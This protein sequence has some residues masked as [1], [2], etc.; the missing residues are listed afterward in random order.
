MRRLGLSTRILLVLLFQM[1]QATVEGASGGEQPRL[2][3]HLLGHQL[4]M[5]Q[6]CAHAPHLVDQ[7]LPLA[8]NFTHP[9]SVEV[10][11]LQRWLGPFTHLAH[12]L[13][14]TWPATGV[15][16]PLQ[17]AGQRIHP[18]AEASAGQPPQAIL[19]STH[20]VNQ[21]IHEQFSKNLRKRS[22]F[23]HGLKN[24]ISRTR[25]TNKTLNK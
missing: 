5:S 1:L 21:W 25:K 24:S 11:G 4:G 19:M 20:N 12:T 15:V 6:A 23:L 3:V 9:A 7:R 2:A 16:K 14:H 22:T 10:V 17:C 18:Q 13:G 8:G